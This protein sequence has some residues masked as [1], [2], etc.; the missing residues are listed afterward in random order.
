MCARKGCENELNNKGLFLMR[1]RKELLSWG[2]GQARAGTQDSV[3]AQV[4]LARRT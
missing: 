2:L 4:S 3:L 1:S